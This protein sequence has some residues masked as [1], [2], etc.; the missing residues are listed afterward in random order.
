MLLLLCGS[1]ELVTVLL[2]IKWI[3]NFV[4]CNGDECFYIYIK[5]LLCLNQHRT[6][7]IHIPAR[8]R[9]IGKA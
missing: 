4:H 3:P 9:S 2:V 8:I 1:V 7:L 5:M 6:Y